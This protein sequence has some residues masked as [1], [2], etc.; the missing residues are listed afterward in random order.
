[1]GSNKPILRIGI[2]TLFH[3]NDNWG[4]YYKGML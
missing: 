1:M 3:N 4:G 2:L